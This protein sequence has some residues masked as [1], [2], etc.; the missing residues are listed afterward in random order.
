LSQKKNLK[1]SKFVEN[2]GLKGK[3]L[4]FFE[5]VLLEK[6]PALSLPKVAFYI[7]ENP[8]QRFYAGCF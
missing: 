5:P 4:F 1:S 6:L 2:K 8:S 7:L 3:T